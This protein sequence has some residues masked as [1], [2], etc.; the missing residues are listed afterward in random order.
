[1]RIALSRFRRS[2]LSALAIVALFLVACGAPESVSVS[3]EPGTGDQPTEAP[4]VSDTASAQLPADFPSDFPLPSD[5]TITDG[6]FTP[7]DAMT[8]ANFVVRG[9]SPSSVEDIADFYLEKLPEAGYEL[10]QAQPPSP[11]ASHAL[12]YFQGENYRDASVQLNG[13]A[14]T[15][16][17]LI[18]LPLRD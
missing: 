1:M 3:Q 14:G 15:T 18:S 12:V 16:N 4:E 5:L 10:I 7:G 2:A 11:G 9:S 6:Q 8:Q 13:E 17:I